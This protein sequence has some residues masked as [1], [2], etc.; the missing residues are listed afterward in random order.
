MRQVATVLAK[1]GAALTL[2]VDDGLSVITRPA[3]SAGVAVP[4]PDATFSE[5]LRRADIALYHAKL[6]RTGPHLYSSGLRQPSHHRHQAPQPLPA[7]TRGS[8]A[9]SGA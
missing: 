6:D 4:E 8:E 5:M 3:A 9:F 2:V 1:L 7:Q